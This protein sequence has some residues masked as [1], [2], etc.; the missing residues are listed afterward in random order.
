MAATLPTTKFGVPFTNW[1][2]S[3]NPGPFNMKEHVLITIF[4]NAGNGSV[5]AVNIITAVKAFYHRKMTASVAFLLSL[6]TQMLGYGWAGLFRKYLVDS[7]YMWWPTNLVQVSLFR[8]LHEEEKRPK[9]GLTRMQFFLVVLVCSFTYYTIPGYL[10]PSISMF[11]I[12]CWF[13]KDSV[14]AQQ[15][16]SGVSG[17]GIGSF[18]FDWLTV[19]GFLSSPLA[20]PAF[21]I[22]NTMAGF[23]LMVYIITPIMYW[24]NVY[25]AKRFPIISSNVYTSDGQ[26]YNVT[27]IMNQK[28]FTIDLQAYNSYSVLN[29]TTF[30][31][32]CYGIGFATLTA[33]LSH[34]A[35]FNGK[36]IWKLWR[37]SRQ[38]ADDDSADVY[39]R[40]M[41]RNYPVVPQWWFV[42]VLV[43]VLGLSL[44]ACEGFGKQL[45]LPYWGLLL[46]C[47]VAL[48]F[49]L[50]IGV[51]TATTNQTP[52]LN[53]IT[54]MIIGYLYPGRP[55]ANVS[56][57]TYGYISMTQALSF[58]QDFKLGHYMKIPP[59]SM[60]YVQEDRQPSL[61]LH[62]HPS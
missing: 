59:K 40:I 19:T 34:V 32:M 58:L 30:F 56:F 28:T 39:T 36:S 37:Q 46:A 23:I 62:Q 43:V 45:Q 18:G 24:T 22:F 38:Q 42:S 5:Y 21:A 48:V 47:A 14:T 7:P 54:E 10:F 3:L 26:H 57:K 44:W 41:K 25:N 15:I 4:A 55:L 20:S 60:F 52:G 33:T 13:W 53:I 17:L 51:I 29:V 27:R 50:P 12:A 49:T 11:S 61:L 16:G 6:T 1:S 9:G 8:T 35:L 2:F 31:A